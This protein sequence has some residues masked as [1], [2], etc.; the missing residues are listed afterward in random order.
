ME[1]EALERVKGCGE[2]KVEHLNS[3]ARSECGVALSLLRNLVLPSSTVRENMLK[4]GE[5]EVAVNEARL[6]SPRQQRA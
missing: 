3:R 5:S 1:A 6:K 4:A 2:D